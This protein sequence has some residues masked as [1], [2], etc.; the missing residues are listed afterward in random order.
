MDRVRQDVLTNNW[1]GSTVT[2][3]SLATVNFAQDF[4]EIGW[5]ARPPILPSTEVESK[6]QNFATSRLLR[7]N[8]SPRPDRAAE[9][10][11]TVPATQKYVLMTAQIKISQNF[12]YL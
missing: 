6:L 5:R 4:H 9:S 8:L 3:E 12:I 10:F 1:I 7:R 11:N 2:A